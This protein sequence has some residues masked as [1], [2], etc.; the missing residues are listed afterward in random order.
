MANS[1]RD[2]IKN[3]ALASAAMMLPQFLKASSFFSGG[4]YKGKRLV[5]IQ[6]SG[7]NDGL[8][9]IVPW[10]NDLY[11]QNRPSIG[12]SGND[13]IRINDDAAFNSNLHGLSELYDDG[14][15]AVI[16]SVGYPNPNRS[17]FRS[18]DIWQSGSDAN[19]YIQSGWVGR[20]L[21][22]TCN[23]QCTMPYAALEI[24]DSLSLAMKGE[25]M[26]GLAMR[27]I[28]K[29]VHSVDDS[30]IQSIANNYSPAGE[31]DH[32]A[33]FLHK[34]LTDTV[35]SASYLSEHSRMFSSKSVYPDHD[36]G[37]QMK[38][39]A[40][41]IISGSET[42]IYYVS[43]PG[44]DT[45]ALQ[46]GIQS[47]QLK[48][49]GDT[50]KVFCHDLKSNNFFNDTV[51]LTFSEF[52]RRVA[53]N[54]SKGTDHGTANNVYIVGGN[55]KSKGLIN[56]MP[57]LQNLSDGDLI[58]QIDFRSVYATIIDKWLMMDSKAI[59]GGTQFDLLNFV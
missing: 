53:Q 36:F 11:Y 47:R 3:T 43:L 46:T 16:N 58:H 14:Y 27:D 12:L 26:K 38:L 33:D 6:L 9:C 8:N 35:H 30:F 49:Y 19:K 2:F 7:G 22:S 56:S 25:R 42:M 24:D 54:G 21:D 51:V 15:V 29:L 52:G 17:H 28:K 13:L 37:R 44:F 1:R 4:S 23:D 39:I 5:V 40:E 20:V 34:T 31:N 32:L 18:M 59:L 10:S 48:V 55:L 41:L 50:L 45:H 57:D